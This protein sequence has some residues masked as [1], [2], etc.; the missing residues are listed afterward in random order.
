MSAARTAV[1][2]TAVVFLIIAFHTFYLN[3]IEAPLHYEGL[4]WFYK[5]S[6]VKSQSRHNGS[7]FLIGVGKGDIT[8]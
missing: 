8:G 2:L 6:G 5:D 1:V 4:P 3:F 7:D